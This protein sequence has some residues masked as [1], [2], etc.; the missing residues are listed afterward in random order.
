MSRPQ[1]YTLWFSYIKHNTL[2]S[3]C[4]ISIFDCNLYSCSSSDNLACNNTSIYSGSYDSH[5]YLK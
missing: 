3:Y 4:D 5:T 1:E 2:A